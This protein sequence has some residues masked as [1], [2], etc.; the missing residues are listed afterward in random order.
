M[1]LTR[2]CENRQTF[3]T[4]EINNKNPHNVKSIATVLKA[5][6][7]SPPPEQELASILQV[8]CS[9]TRA[10]SSGFISG[11]KALGLQCML[12]H[13]AM[14]YVCRSLQPMKILGLI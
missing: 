7:D 11:L 10:W 6:P 3:V 8:S 5:M 14:P 13:L 9:L 4:A 1:E 2:L 12:P